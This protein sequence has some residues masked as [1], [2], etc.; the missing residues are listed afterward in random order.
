MQVCVFCAAS[1]SERKPQILLDQTAEQLWSSWGSHWQPERGPDPGTGVCTLRKVAV[2]VWLVVVGLAFG[3]LP[4]SPAKPPTWAWIPPVSSRV[5]MQRV[6]RGCMLRVRQWQTFVLLKICFIN[7]GLIWFVWRKSDNIHLPVLILIQPGLIGSD[8]H[9]SGQWKGMLV[10][11]GHCICRTW[12][13]C[14]ARCLNSG[15][16]QIVASRWSASPSS[17]HT[18]WA[19]EDIHH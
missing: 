14:L 19:V 11:K 10:K 15:K 12:N 16:H 8:I 5:C 6:E 4:G 17:H 7:P 9:L 13:V 18:S 1:E 2:C 3:W